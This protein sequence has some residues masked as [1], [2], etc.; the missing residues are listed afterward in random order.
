MEH[1]TGT[2]RRDAPEARVTSGDG[3]AGAAP[4]LARNGFS[5]KTFDALIHYADFRVLWIAFLSSGFG[6]ALEMFA[7][8]WLVWQI[9][10][11]G[12]ALGTLGFTRGI[13]GLLAVPVAGVVADRMDRRLVIQTASTV[14]A[15]AILGLALLISFE[16]VTLWQVILVAAV[17][18]LTTSFDMP[19][20]QALIPSIVPR[21]GLMNAAALNSLARNTSMAIG[22]GLAGFLAGSFGLAVAYYAQFVLLLL[23]VV[24]LFLVKLPPPNSLARRESPL[25]NLKTGFTYAVSDPIVR[26]VLLVT[27]TTLALGVAQGQ[28]LPAY[29]GTVLNAGPEVYGIILST[30]AIV[31][32][33]GGIV[34]A[35]L[36]DYPHKGRLLLVAALIPLVTTWTLALTH[37]LPTAMFAQSVMSLG[38][39]MFVPVT[40][41]VLMKNVPD[42]LLGRIMTLV[43]IQPAIIS[44]GGIIYG[45]G[46]DL[47]GLRA[48]Y[49]LLGAISAATV[50]YLWFTTP[51]FRRLS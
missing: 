40:T 5:F 36:G 41:S 46:A 50:L 43:S 7:S 18:G 16:R 38:G 42:H 15:M 26:V 37:W 21:E 11:S 10:G 20:R 1:R 47:F 32:F 22:P 45:T 23:P 19:V 28:V 12:L 25:A 4:R 31:G 6:Q 13:A 9:T 49:L 14:R 35:S 29:V 17:S 24:L 8:S 51:Q 27:V 30:A 44:L 2:T 39:S 34:V 33:G 48:T 3:G